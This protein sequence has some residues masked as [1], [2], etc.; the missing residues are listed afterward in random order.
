MEQWVKDDTRREWRELGF[1][2]D[3]DDA[4]KEWRL[5][6]SR[7]GLRRFSD[8]LRVYVGDPRNEAKS[9]HEHYGPYMYLELMTWPE[10]DIDDHT[11][12]GPLTALEHL[13]SL[14]EARI[15]AMKPGANVRIRDDFAAGTSYALV[16]DL[17]DD[18][19]DPSSLDA[20]LAGD[21]G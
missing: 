4:S 21:A 16:L 14:V 17:R 20:N 18:D 8:L 6:G 9:E 2:Y 5:V 12:R 19:F 3:R 10:A 7:A 1:F 13:A 15:G 11:I